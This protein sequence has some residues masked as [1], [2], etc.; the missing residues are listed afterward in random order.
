MAVSPEDEKVSEASAKMNT[1]A[2]LISPGIYVS[3][4]GPR[5]SEKL[6]LEGTEYSRK[7]WEKG[8]VILFETGKWRQSD[9]RMQLGD[10]DFNL[11]DVTRD[12]FSLLIDGNWTFWSDCFFCSGPPSNN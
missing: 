1:T 10:K 3:T 5:I 4:I 7:R 11:K 2:T 12:S 6:V 8:S 9:D